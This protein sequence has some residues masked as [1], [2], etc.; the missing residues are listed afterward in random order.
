MYFARGKSLARFDM[1]TRQSED[2]PL[3]FAPTSL[4][5]AP[6]ASSAVFSTCRVHYDA[7]RVDRDGGV[8]P[9]PAMSESAGLIV[10]GP[11][12]ELAFPVAI[13]TGTAVGVTDTRGEHV[14]VLTSPDYDVTEAAFSP[15]GRRL[16]FHDA[17]ESGGGLFV[18][19]TDGK[20]RAARLTQNSQDNA[21]GWIDD[22][23]VVYMRKIPG[24]VLGGVPSRGTILLAIRSPDGDRF[25]EATL[26]GRLK[27][28]PLRGVP[29]GQHWEIATGI[30]P[31]GRYAAWFSGGAVWRADLDEG[32]AT[33]VAFDWPKGVADGLS[34]D[35]EGRVSVSFRHSEGQLYRVTGSFP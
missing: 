31:S 4:A 33:R 2:A 15:D 8:T 5:I 9:L 11:H 29:K 14:H 6:D 23:R 28:R 24:I 21:P 1:D 25:A 19:N 17:R 10:V 27:E 3:P 18:I 35:D 34:S 30:S 22:D 7:R 16:V 12:G 13:G 32:N 26:D 20:S